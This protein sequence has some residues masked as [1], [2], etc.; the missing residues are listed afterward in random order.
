MFIVRI[1]P[2]AEAFLGFAPTLNDWL[3]IFRMYFWYAPQCCRQEDGVDMF[4]L[5]R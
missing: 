5:A 2:C 4:A 1:I 3:L